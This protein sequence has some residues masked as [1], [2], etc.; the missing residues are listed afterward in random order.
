M[1]HEETPGRHNACDGVPALVHADLIC[2]ASVRSEAAG[3]S[4]VADV[5]AEN[6]ATHE[7]AIATRRVGLHSSKMMG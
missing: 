5:A 7:A 1:D 4:K 3:C 2:G 6:N